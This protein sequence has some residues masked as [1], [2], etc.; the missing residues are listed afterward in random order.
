MCES[1]ENYVPL[2]D[3]MSWKGDPNATLLGQDAPQLPPGSPSAVAPAPT[4]PALAV[5]QYDPVNRSYIAPD[6][7][8]YYLANLA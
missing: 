4:F 1:D 3:G 6:G 8:T 5:T 2:N 7:N